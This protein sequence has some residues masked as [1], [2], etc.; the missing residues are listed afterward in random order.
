MKKLL[1][2]LALLC[3][4]LA[5]QSNATEQNQIQVQPQMPE[6]NSTSEIATTETL[7]N[8]EEEIPSIQILSTMTEK[9]LAPNRIWV[10]TFQL[11]WNEI[12]ETITKEPVKFVGFESPLANEL[13]KKEFTKND[14]SELAYYVKSGIVSPQL[15][16][17]IEKDIKSKFME[18]SDIL[19]RF[20]WRRDPHKLFVYAMLKKDFKFILPFEKLSDG[21]F[22]QNYSPVKYFGTS[23]NSPKM[24][25]Q[26]IHILFHNADNDFAVKLYTKGKDIVL[27]YRTD[28]EK[29][30]EEYFA[31]I[32]S[33]AIA[34]TETR[35]FNKEDRLSVPEINL[36]QETNF[37]ELEGHQIAGTNY[38]IDKTIETIDFKMDNVG[39]KVKSEAAAS[40]KCM[41]LEPET[42][43]Y[44]MFTDKFVLFLIEKNKNIPY[45]AM[46]VNDIETLNKTGKK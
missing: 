12:I 4:T 22:G 36:Y 38:E 20:D 7:N 18:K 35:T 5:L 32:N 46:R 14:L 31:D 40:V 28:E 34:Y 21:I 39:V 23:E 30:F 16:K 1:I 15:K 26:T 2:S 17:R 45:Y 43:R 29:T 13:N 8:S 10:G 11:V 42:G 19:D 27:L 9:S 37:P 33:K 25:T 6:L 44:F 41:S 24:L 3:S